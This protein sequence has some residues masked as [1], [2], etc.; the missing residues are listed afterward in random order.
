ML[1]KSQGFIDALMGPV[2]LLKVELDKPRSDDPLGIK[3]LQCAQA[4]SVLRTAEGLLDQ[5]SAWRSL[6]SS[7]APRASAS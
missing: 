2:K 6:T 3:T 7:R 4:M 1:A 5:A